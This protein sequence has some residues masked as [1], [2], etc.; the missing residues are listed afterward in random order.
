MELGEEFQLVQVLR[1]TSVK[2][3]VFVFDVPEQKEPIGP[4]PSVPPL[5]VDHNIFFVRLPEE[6]GS[7]PIFIPP[8]RQE[9]IVYVLN[10]KDEQAQRVIEGKNPTLPIGV[11]L[12]TALGSA[13]EADGQII[14]S[15]GAERGGNTG[16][17]GGLVGGSGFGTLSLG[18]GGAAAGSGFGT[19]S[20]GLGGAGAGSRFGAVSREYS[21]SW[22]TCQPC[23][24]FVIPKVIP[25]G[26]Q[27]YKAA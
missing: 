3:K 5:R 22:I 27:V 18:F 20:E 4:P 2:R 15:A 6:G 24:A 21:V 19:V 25:V 17:V 12:N 11:D 23:E 9:N 16:G 14:G 13:A 1:Y 7:K 8:P 26:K 10:K